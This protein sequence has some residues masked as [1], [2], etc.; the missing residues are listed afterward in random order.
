MTAAEQEM[1]HVKVSGVIKR[2]GS[3]VRAAS[4][5]RW[6]RMSVGR[7]VMR[8]KR[9]YREHVCLMWTPNNARSRLC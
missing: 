9:V 3:N 6:K 5:C 1:R 8:D 4:V 7:R 2:I